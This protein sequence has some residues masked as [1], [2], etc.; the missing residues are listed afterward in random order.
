MYC[1]SEDASHPFESLFRKDTSSGWVS[2]AGPVYPVECVIDPGSKFVLTG[3]EVISHQSMIPSRVDLYGTMSEALDSSCVWESIGFFSFNDNERSQWQA[4][5]LKRIRIDHK[6]LRFLRMVI[7]GCHEVPPNVEKRC[8][9]VSLEIQGRKDTKP[10][11]ASYEQMVEEINANK[12]AAVEREDYGTAADYKEQ[13]QHAVEREGELRELFRQKDEALANEEYLLVDRIVNQILAIIRPSDDDW[14]PEPVRPVVEEPRRPPPPEPEPEPVKE[15]EPPKELSGK[16]EAFFVT[17]FGDRAKVLSPPEDVVDLDA[18]QQLVEPQFNEPVRKPRKVPKK[19]KMVAERV[20]KVKQADG[21]SARALPNFND[22]PKQD[23][24]DELSEEHRAE[25]AALIS[26]FGESPVAMAYSSGWMN[27]VNGYKQLCELIAGLKT[28]NEKIRA[29]RGLM[30]LVHENLEGGLKAVFCPA[31]EQTITMVDAIDLPPNEFLAF[32]HQILPAVMTK[33]GDSNP[34]INESANHFVLWAAEK[35]PKFSMNELV[36]WILKPLSS[37]N[38][39]HLLTAKMVLLKIIIERHGIGP[40]G[41]VKLPEVMNL[42]VPCLESR[43][44]EVRQQS[45]DLLV[46]IYPLV[47]TA[48]DKYLSTAPRIVKDQLKAAVAKL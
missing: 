21:R 4:R 30:P 12:Q 17:E 23:D 22:V 3:M 39:Y 44:A 28:A 14:E 7:S 34:R 27:K 35:D 10:K 24:P 20:P 11:L 25:A 31:V 41:K 37:Q 45:F 15:P 46:S 40:N 13:L 9:F 5:E 36:Q 19:P 42:V 6:R 16:S 38:Q 32:V 1:S 8:S 29:F 2:A 33:L 47:G 48:M 18:L 43:K 26:L